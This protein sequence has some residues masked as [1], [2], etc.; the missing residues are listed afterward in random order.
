MVRIETPRE[1]AGAVYCGGSASPVGCHG[2]R[3][4]STSNVKLRNG[5]DEDH[6][7]ENA[8]SGEREA[9]RDR[10][11]DI[12]G[13][14]KLK[15]QQDSAPQIVTEAADNLPG[16]DSLEEPK[17]HREQSEQGNGCDECDAQTFDD[18]GAQFRE[19][20]DQFRHSISPAAVRLTMSPARRAGRSGLS[21]YGGA[22]PGSIH[23]NLTAL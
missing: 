16:F 9:R 8:N 4:S 13:D 14:E 20:L 5:P 21:E 7:T 1:I 23:D 18:P 15:V 19:R 22:G 12:R 3:L 6:D 11:D 2:Q 17:S 10:M